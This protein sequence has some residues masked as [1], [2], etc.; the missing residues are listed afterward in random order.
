MKLGIMQPYFFP[1]LG[2]FDLINRV[3]QWIVFDTAQYIRHGWVNRNRILHPTAA[4]QYIIVPLKK[5]GRNTAINHVETQPYGQWRCRML[6]QLQHYKKRAPGFASAYSLVEECLS[7][8]ELNLSRLNVLALQKTCD[9]IGIRFSYKIF[10]EMNLKL[11]EVNGPGDWALRIA[12]ALGAT[13]YLNPPGGIELF[14]PA[15]F[16]A[17]KIKLTIQMPFEFNYECRGY[18]FEPALSVIDALMWNSPQDIK[19]YLESLKD[20]SNSPT[21]SW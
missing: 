7:Y 4:W 2:Y 12:Q 5:H 9:K 6:G 21:F 1:Y 17:S 10:S 16:V 19:A 20:K 18:R 15:A 13:E 3:D 14:D 8:G 11:S